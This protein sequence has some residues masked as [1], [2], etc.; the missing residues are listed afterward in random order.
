MRDSRLPS[1]RDVGSGIKT[2]S[3]ASG[4]NG[5]QPWAAPSTPNQG[6]EDPIEAARW[7]R[8]R[9][10]FF[11]AAGNGVS[12]AIGAAATELAVVFEREEPNTDYGIMILPGWSTTAYVPDADKATT[13]F[14]ARFGT[15]SPGGGSTVSFITFRS[16][17]S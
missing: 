4:P 7:Q 2:G 12:L 9:L 17:D 6:L 3:D 10:R 8:L 13:G 1:I 15:A 11:T 14:T 16:E 5:V